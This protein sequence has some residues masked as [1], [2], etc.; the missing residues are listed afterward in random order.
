M[1]KENAAKIIKRINLGETCRLGIE[2]EDYSTAVKL[3]RRAEG[4]YS[5][6]QTDAAIYEVMAPVQYSDQTFATPEDLERFL[7]NYPPAEITI[8]DENPLGG[9][10]KEKYAMLL[11]C[12]GD[13]AKKVYVVMQA[14][15]YTPRTD[16]KTHF[17]LS[18]VFASARP[19]EGMLDYLR[20]RQRA[21]CY[22]KEMGL[23]AKD[24]AVQLQ[25]NVSA[26]ET[27]TPIQIVASILHLDIK[28][29]FSEES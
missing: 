28:R 23:A 20:T 4:G 24:G 2:Q 3:K 19:A 12:L 11:S 26:Q 6:Q 5:S 10:N 22:L 17:I 25:G 13:K 27:L 9:R 29:F 1:D 21:N 18:G 8:I 16:G 15:K 7:I 14:D